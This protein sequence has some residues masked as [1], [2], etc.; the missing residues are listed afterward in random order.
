MEDHEITEGSELE[1]R[2]RRYKRKDTT[3][4]TYVS[5]IVKEEQRTT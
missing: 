4:I 1:E 2:K 5:Q 3:M